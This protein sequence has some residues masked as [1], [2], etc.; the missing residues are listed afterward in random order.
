M[1]VES[2][3]DDIDFGFGSAEAFEGI[4]CLI[5]HINDDIGGLGAFL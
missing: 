3:A 2:R 4:L 1:L 5:L